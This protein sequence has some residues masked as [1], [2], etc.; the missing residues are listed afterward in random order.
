MSAPKKPSSAKKRKSTTDPKVV[1]RGS[2]VEVNG[3][4]YISIDHMP[5]I[6][7]SNTGIT[8]DGLQ[9][10]RT[11]IHLA[12]LSKLT[13]QQKLITRMDAKIEKLV[14]AHGMTP[15]DIVEFD[16]YDYRAEMQK[17]RA[18]SEGE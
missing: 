5:K 16:V 8:V 9:H 10:V 13:Q 1:L 14:T 3:K 12:A 6:T 4:H 15:T 2:H 18:P 7:V 17:L 11:E